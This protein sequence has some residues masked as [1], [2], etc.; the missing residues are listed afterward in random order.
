MNL[1]LVYLFLPTFSYCCNQTYFTTL[2]IRKNLNLYFIY[3]NN[4]F[5]L[6]EINTNTEGITTFIH[7]ILSFGCQV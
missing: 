2:D 7:T 3:L 5:Y 4:D 6:Q 1:S